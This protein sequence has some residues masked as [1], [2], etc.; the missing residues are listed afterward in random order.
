MEMD[1]IGYLNNLSKI[2]KVRKMREK[3]IT[4]MLPIMMEPKLAIPFVLTKSI[5]DV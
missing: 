3:Y 4:W 2:A 5:N 1:E